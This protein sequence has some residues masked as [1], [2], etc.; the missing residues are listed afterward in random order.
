MDNGNNKGIYETITALK[1]SLS[2]EDQ[3]DVAELG[4]LYFID[5]TT[6]YDAFYFPVFSQHRKDTYGEVNTPRNLATELVSFIPWDKWLKNLNGDSSAITETLLSKTLPRVLDSGAGCGYI[7]A[8]VV[9]NIFHLILEKYDKTANVVVSHKDLWTTVMKKMTLVELHAENTQLLTLL[10]G[11]YCTI[12]N[13]DYLNY[14]PFLYGERVDIV[15]GNPPFNINGNIK[16]PTNH[17]ISKKDDGKSIW[18]NFV[19]HSLDH[20]LDEGGYLCY[21]MPSLWMKNDDKTG[22]FN[23]ILTENKLLKVKCYNNTTSNV[24]FKGHAQTHCGCFLIQ[25]GGKTDIVDYFSWYLNDFTDYDRDRASIEHGHLRSICVLD[26]VIE[27]KIITKLET[28]FKTHNIPIKPLRFYKTST[29]SKKIS[30]SSSSTELHSYKNIKTCLLNRDNKNG[31]IRNPCLKYEYSDVP[32][33]FYGV[34]KLVCAH[35]MYGVPF[36]DKKGDYGISRRD[37][38]VILEEDVCSLEKIAWFLSTPIM[39]FMFENYK[40][41]MCFLEKAGFDWLMDISLLADKNMPF[42]DIKE[43][44][45]WFGFT[46]AERDYIKTFERG[47]FSNVVML[48]L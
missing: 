21:Y 28:V 19:R 13:R 22:L 31:N 46:D 35:G 18:R 32:C 2:K 5:I 3:T 30:V 33:P 39:S 40:Y 7:S 24:M 43:T 26:C 4:L 36:L 47:Q 12:I 20:C 6:F 14:F 11:T 8:V 34:A 44:Y 29:L 41:R 16:V 17:H 38:Y 37:K 45:E 42:G 23:V 15:I 27:R 9:K 25:K 48:I 10:F 1:A